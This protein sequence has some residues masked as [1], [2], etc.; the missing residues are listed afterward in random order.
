MRRRLGKL[1]ATI[2]AVFVCVSG[3]S[4]QRTEVTVSVSEQFFDA[5]LDATF[6]NY[7]PPE[8]SISEFRG[9]PSDSSGDMS[10]LWS[11]GNASGPSSEVGN[12]CGSV[13]VLRESSGVRTA[14][15]FREG[16]VYV[17]L[18]F[19]GSYAPPFIGCV[20][21]A[22]VAESIV[23]LEYDQQNRRLIGRVRVQTINLN[24]T[25][26]IGGTMIARL[27]QG[28]IDRKFNPVEILSLEKVSIGLPVPNTGKLNM[29]AI[30][31]RPEVSSGAMNIHIEYEFLKG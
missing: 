16:K 4:A 20:D 22:G 9:Q 10:F 26:G 24:G 7:D 6:K 27:L 3:L 21:F 25:G 18:A 23:D 8:F 13:K 5:L 11:T 30:G 15:R 2:V 28:S 31:V 29:H 14:I 17:P 1:S 12:E 19:S